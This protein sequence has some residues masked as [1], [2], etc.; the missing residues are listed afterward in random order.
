MMWMKVGV[1]YTRALSMLSYAIVLPLI[2]CRGVWVVCLR[3]VEKNRSDR[4]GGGLTHGSQQPAREKNGAKCTQEKRK[5]QRPLSREISPHF[6]GEYHPSCDFKQ[7]TPRERQ[8]HTNG[9]RSTVEGEGWRKKRERERPRGGRRPWRGET[10]ELRRRR[11]R[12]WAPRRAET[13]GS[14]GG[15]RSGAGRRGGGA[16][17]Q[18]QPPH[19]GLRAVRRQEVHWSQAL[20]AW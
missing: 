9:A 1:V 11:S 20:P 8:G 14:R 5:N 10:K 15:H 18:R 6:D 19:V 16:I 12:P 7:Q 13:W 2:W 4:K 17:D 3:D